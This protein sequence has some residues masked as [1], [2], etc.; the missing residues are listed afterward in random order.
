MQ[1]IS[2]I[3]MAFNEAG[4]IETVVLEIKEVLDNQAIPYEIIIVNDGSSD[5]T[6]II[7][8]KLSNKFQAIKLI[9][10][11]E[12]LGLGE[13]Y[14][15]GF[16]AAQN[17]LLTFFPADG[18]FPAEI[19]RQFIPLMRTMDMVLGFLPDRK[20]SLAGMI[21]SAVER[22]IFRLLIGPLP[23][24]QGIM[25]F[26]RCLLDEVLL[27][28]SG[29][30]WIILLEL[31]IRASREH[32]RITSIPTDIQPRVYGKSKVNNF[33]TIIA[34]FKQIIRLHRLIRA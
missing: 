16:N 26:R 18:Q 1:S 4:S 34:N 32:Y 9:N 22:W 14:R 33:Q 21:L 13:V 30:G 10:H 24:F 31:I 25:M 15:T 12:N 6:E 29:R 7:A 19:I 3:V 23:K 27:K 20:D 17:E 5:D 28:S 2:V 11:P 8:S